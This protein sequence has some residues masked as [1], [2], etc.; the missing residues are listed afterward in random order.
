MRRGLPAVPAA[1][2]PAVLLPA[3]LLLSGCAG[4]Q[5]PDADAVTAA[6][7]NRRAD[8]VYSMRHP[9]QVYGQDIY[10]SSLRDAPFGTNGLPSNPSAGLSGQYERERM[11]QDCIDANGPVGPTPAAPP[12]AAPDVPQ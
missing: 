7:C 1:L 10:T 2:L 4:G 5:G 12:V 3:A 11:A 9:E 6:A 8:Q